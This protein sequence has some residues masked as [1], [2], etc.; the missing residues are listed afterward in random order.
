[1]RAIG[2]DFGE[3]FQAEADA[4]YRLA[5]L[6]LRDPDDAEDAVQDALLRLFR[7]GDDPRDY[8]N[9][10]AWMFRVLIS[11]CQD[12]RRARRR[13]GR[14]F[15]DTEVE[16]DSY[17]DGQTQTGE[18]QLATADALRNTLSL[19]RQLPIADAEAL[20]LVAIEGLSY[21][22]TAEI[23][24]TPIGTVRSRVSRARQALKI[25]AENG[26]PQVASR[27]RT[28]VPFSRNAYRGSE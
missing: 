10:R 8:D 17:A 15:D 4:L 23:Q 5:L 18:S 20:A 22:E 2:A 14:L 26:P 9:P 16:P 11:V 21:A 25:A 3:L 13:H 7:R 27:E 1:M 24:E 19:M 12:R 6:R 28:I